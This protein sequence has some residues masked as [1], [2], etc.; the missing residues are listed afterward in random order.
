MSERVAIGVR[1]V[2]G[3]EV[4]EKGAPPEPP[5]LCECCPAARSEADIQ[6]RTEDVD[7]VADGGNRG[8]LKRNG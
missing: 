4:R 3:A 5:V 7:A 1:G 2:E 8:R 6:T